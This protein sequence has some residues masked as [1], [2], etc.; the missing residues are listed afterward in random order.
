MVID[1]NN[2]IN[3]ANTGNTRARAAAGGTGGREGGAGE[4]DSRSREDVVLSPAA[5]SLAR[6]EAQIQTATDV[7]GDKVAAIKQ[8][9]ENGRFEI[10]AERIADRLLQQDDLLG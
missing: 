1:S 6:L 5:Q 10:N 3:P 2:G 7:D 4:A 8:A 9:I